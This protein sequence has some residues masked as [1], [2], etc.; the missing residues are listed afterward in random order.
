MRFSPHRGYDFNNSSFFYHLYILKDCQ[1]IYILS[2]S[3]NLG[4][5]P[6]FTLVT[7]SS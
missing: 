5:D 7:E 6:R 4:L 1:V 2:I 3:I